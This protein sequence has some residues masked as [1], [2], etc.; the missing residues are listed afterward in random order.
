MGKR[1]AYV[2]FCVPF[3]KRMLAGK[4][5]E[6]GHVFLPTPP[7]SMGGAGTSGGRRLP[8]ALHFLSMPLIP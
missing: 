2:C 1:M 4:L 5:L 3:P 7:M 8:V 6:Y